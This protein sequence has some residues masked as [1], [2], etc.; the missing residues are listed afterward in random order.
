[1]NWL[2]QYPALQV[3]ALYSLH[4]GASYW[5]YDPSTGKCN[6]DIEKDYFS[7]KV[8]AIYI[9][10]YEGNTRSRLR[11]GVFLYEDRLIVATGNHAL[12]IEKERNE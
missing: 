3:G 8:N 7:E 11:L 12:L 5:H 9:K 1:M 10:P 2:E 6:E 4:Q